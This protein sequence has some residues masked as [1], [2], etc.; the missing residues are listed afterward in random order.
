M[1]ATAGNQCH[2]GYRV[3]LGVPGASPL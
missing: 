2:V 3:D 1:V